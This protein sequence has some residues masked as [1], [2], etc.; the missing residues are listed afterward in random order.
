MNSRKSIVAG[1]AGVLLLTS[2]FFIGKLLTESTTEIALIP[3]KVVTYVPTNIVNNVQQET[4]HMR[5]LKE[6]M[7]AYRPYELNEERKLDPLAH[8]KT[9]YAIDIELVHEIRD[10]NDINHHLFYTIYR[11]GNGDV[12]PEYSSGRLF[13]SVTHIPQNHPI[14]YYGFFDTEITDIEPLGNIDVNSDGSVSLYCSKD[15]AILKYDCEYKVQLD[16]ENRKL[17]MKR[18]H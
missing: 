2:G 3:K 7:E 1:I 4:T 13:L 9:D 16:L 8:D 5:S 10:I 14:E 18:I 15:S 17:Y 11:V 12:P 6:I